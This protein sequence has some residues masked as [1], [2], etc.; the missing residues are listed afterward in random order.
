MNK[1][2]NLGLKAGPITIQVM[3]QRVEEKSMLSKRVCK[4]EEKVE[5][6]RGSIVH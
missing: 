4:K 3:Q 2:T 1:N 5:K 6:N